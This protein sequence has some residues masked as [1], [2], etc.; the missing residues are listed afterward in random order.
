MEFDSAAACSPGTRAVTLAA[1]SCKTPSVLFAN[2]KSK[3]DAG[4]PCLEMGGIKSLQDMS[5]N[6]WVQQ[7]LQGVFKLGARSLSI[8]GAFHRTT[9]WL[10]QKGS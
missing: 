2:A 8:T 1:N 9:E 10:G 4:G 7:I 5:K 6:L 3:C